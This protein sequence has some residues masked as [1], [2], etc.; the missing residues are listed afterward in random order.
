MGLAL[1]SLATKHLL[2]QPRA[3][4]SAPAKFMLVGRRLPQ[5][6]LPRPVPAP[7]PPA[8]DTRF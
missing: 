7:L 4:L 1:G 6:N 5:E 2:V 3:A 8:S